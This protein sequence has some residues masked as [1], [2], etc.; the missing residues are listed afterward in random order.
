MFRV[1]LPV[2]L[3]SCNRMQ[4]QARNWENQICEIDS[5]ISILSSMSGM[6]AVVGRLKQKREDLTVQKNDLLHMMMC[7]ERIIRI[8]ESSEASIV[9]N[10]EPS[11]RIGSKIIVDV[12]NG[13]VGGPVHM[14]NAKVY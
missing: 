2:L 7:L 10:A 3:D 6:Q 9:S 8:Y 11:W 13:I 12:V 1:Y 14:I 5:V 4:G